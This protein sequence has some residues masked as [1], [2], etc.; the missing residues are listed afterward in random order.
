MVKLSLRQLRVHYRRT[1]AIIV[2]TTV[3]IITCRSSARVVTPLAGVGTAI[4]VV[5]AAFASPGASVG[6]PRA[7]V[8]AAIARILTT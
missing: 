4:P 8:A 7:L 6:T 3:P 5:T 1:L 2:A